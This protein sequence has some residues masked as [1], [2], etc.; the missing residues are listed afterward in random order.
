MT[1]PYFAL[2]PTD[3][4]ADVGHLGNTELGVYWRLLLVYY[5]DGR[6]LPFETDRLRRIAMTFSPEECRALDSVVAE[7][8]TLSTEPDGTRVWRHKRAD[9]ELQAA[10]ERHAAAVAKAQRA[11]E[12]RWGRGAREFQRV[13]PSSNEHAPGNAPSMPEAMLVQCQPEPEPDIPPI[14]PPSSERLPP[15]GA[16]PRRDPVAKPLGVA[17]LVEDGVDP[18]IAAEWFAIRKAKRMPLTA[19]GWNATVREAGKMGLSP[20]DAVKLAVERG[21]AGFR[22]EYAAQAK[23]AETTYQR[24]MR[25]RA[26]QIHPALAAPAP[27]QHDPMAVIDMAVAESRRALK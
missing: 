24:S 25:E 7:F 6:P 14:S 10:Q 11:A 4:L 27:G 8:F 21:W 22:A 23:P 3:F 1:A 5:R 12:A 2:Y 9:R 18:Q 26:A 19:T 20:G 16:K 15:K 17:E 13:P